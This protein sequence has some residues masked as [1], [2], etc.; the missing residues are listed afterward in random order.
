MNEPTSQFESRKRDHIELA[1]QDENEACGG[2][3]FERIQLNHEALPDHNFSEINLNT[4]IL[5]QSRLTPFFVSSMTAGHA[6]SINLNLRLAMA[7]AERGWMMGVGSQRR[8]LF[9]FENARKEWLEVRKQAPRAQL[10][11]NI[12]LS[13]LITATNKQILGLIESLEAEALI[14]HLNALQECLQ[15]EGTPSFKGGLVR[16]SEIAKAL[17]VPVIVKETGCGFSEATLKQ[18]KEVGVSAVDVSGYGGTHWGRIEGRR[19]V[20][21]SIQQQAA[22]TY[23]HWGVSTVDSLLNARRIKPNF[24]VWAS[25]GVRTGLDAAKALALGASAVGLAK[26]ILSAALES[27]VALQKVM[28]TVEYELKIAIFCTGGVQVSDLHN[29]GVLK[30]NKDL[31]Q[32]DL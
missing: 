19:Q 2:S 9:D 32:G 16:I 6:G 10:L 31:S 22:L 17:S 26:P 20:A 1:L 25:G 4:Q 11:S 18:L 8:E 13:Q 7:C 23:A 29:S 15:L 12:G 21:N 5:G 27:E 30:M 3:G 14:V 24:E 28:S